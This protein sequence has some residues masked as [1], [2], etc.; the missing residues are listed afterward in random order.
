MEMELVPRRKIFRHSSSVIAANATAI[1]H[2]S[3]LAEMMRIV[4]NTVQRVRSRRH[5][6]R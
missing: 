2:I 5:T 3:E 1:I 4:P 6:P